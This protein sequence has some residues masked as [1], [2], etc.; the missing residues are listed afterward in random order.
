VES[1]DLTLTLTL[2]LSL[3]PN[4]D[5]VDLF[6]Y[7]L[8]HDASTAALRQID[9]HIAEDYKG[10]YERES[11]PAA[12]TFTKKK[13]DDTSSI[14]DRQRNRPFQI[15]L[16]L[17][18]SRSQILE[19]FDLAPCKALA[20]LDPESEELIVEAL[21]LFINSLR[22]MA[23]HVDI[24]Y[25]SPASIARIMKYIAKGFEC[26]V[27]GV[28]RSAFKTATGNRSLRRYGRGQG[29]ISELY[30]AEA[31]VTN[32]R[33][34]WS[35]PNEV[36]KRKGEMVFGDELVIEKITG[37]LTLV[38]AATIASKVACRLGSGR[39]KVKAETARPRRDLY[40][41]D[42]GYGG[43]EGWDFFSC[44][45]GRKHGTGT[46]GFI[47]ESFRQDVQVRLGDSRRDIGL[48]VKFWTFTNAGRFQPSKACLEELYNIDELSRVAEE[49][50][51]A[52]A[53]AVQAPGGYGDCGACGEP[54]TL[55]SCE[56]CDAVFYCDEKCLEA[57]CARHEAECEAMQEVEDT[58][59]SD[60]S[61]DSDEENG[62]EEDGAN[63][64]PPEPSD[65]EENECPAVDTPT[66]DG[67]W[68]WSPVVAL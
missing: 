24:M 54:Y 43:E 16:G 15:I 14:D 67:K 59:N 37:R 18:R 32:S 39:D 38:E 49:E 7:G 1:N 33:H 62:E 51:A 52:R 11:S 45:S 12:V 29:S 57:D 2:S 68:Q 41:D 19:Y 13:H 64:G 25:W 27:P 8:D 26:V 61:D 5:Q 46:Y 50:V 65:K 63:D 36:L 23:F 20:R 30:D 44:Y 10:D 4:P 28:R 58:D 9:A 56:L 66:R 22:R 47:R 17:H 35:E 21:P 42:E 3:P 53:A 6:L 34:Y 48:D 31:E 55:L 60:D 40:S